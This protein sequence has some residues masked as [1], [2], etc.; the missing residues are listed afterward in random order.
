VL[1]FAVVAVGTGRDARQTDK[2]SPAEGG[3]SCAVLLGDGLE[4]LLAVQA[5]VFADCVLKQSLVDRLGR[6]PA[7]AV[8]GD[9]GGRTSLVVVPHGVFGLGQQGFGLGGFDGRTVLG[10][11]IRLATKRL[12]T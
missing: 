11:R 8:D 7:F 4:V 12:V 6:M 1:V 10:G 3:P 2:L 5:A 9:G